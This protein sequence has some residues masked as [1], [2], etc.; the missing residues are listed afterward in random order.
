MGSWYKN[1]LDGKKL[2]KIGRLLGT[3]EYNSFHKVFLVKNNFFQFVKSLTPYID[4]IKT[5]I[6]VSNSRKVSQETSF[7]LEKV[8]LSNVFKTNVTK[9]PN[10]FP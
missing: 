5:H 8:P 3:Q 4:I 9:L 2:I 7:S 1:V 10:S 6:N